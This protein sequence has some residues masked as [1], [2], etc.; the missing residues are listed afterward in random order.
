M[1]VLRKLCDEEDGEK[2]TK[3]NRNMNMND[4]KQMPNMPSQHH[5]KTTWSH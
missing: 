3:K 5:K 1:E 2:K 4:E